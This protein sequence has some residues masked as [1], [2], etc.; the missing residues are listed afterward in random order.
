[1]G[2]FYKQW[3]VRA[4]VDVFL[5]SRLRAQMNRTPDDR[6]GDKLDNLVCGAVEC[7]TN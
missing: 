1:M 2:G 5:K 6:T 7:R 3:Y 4:T